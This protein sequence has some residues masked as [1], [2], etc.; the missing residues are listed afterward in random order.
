MD[1]KGL[2]QSLECSKH[3]NKKSDFIISSTIIIIILSLLS[4]VHGIVIMLL[5]QL[6]K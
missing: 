2:Q 4:I 6:R 3:L 1:I 5:Y